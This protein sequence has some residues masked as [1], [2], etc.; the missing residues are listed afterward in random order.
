MV[1]ASLLEQRLVALEGV[2]VERAH[3]IRDFGDE[4]GGS[5]R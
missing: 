4:R 3:R 2:A 5:T 1:E